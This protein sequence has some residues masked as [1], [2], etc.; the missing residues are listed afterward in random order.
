MQKNEAFI[1]L[2][3][4]YLPCV[5]YV[6]SMKMKSWTDNWTKFYVNRYIL[7]KD[8]SVNIL[9]EQKHPT[10]NSFERN[11]GT[12]S[13]WKVSLQQWFI[14][15]IFYLCFKFEL[16]R[17]S[18]SLNLTDQ[19]RWTSSLSRK[20]DENHVF[21]YSAFLE[22]DNSMLCFGKILS[23][24]WSSWLWYFDTIILSRSQII[25]S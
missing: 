2:D 3:I 25:S 22:R 20:N 1:N 18:G 19:M 6:L 12:I 9:E 11:F 14:M 13:F 5:G 8:V 21:E 4:R 7:P 10:T 23:E 15:E 24:T 17:S 16:N